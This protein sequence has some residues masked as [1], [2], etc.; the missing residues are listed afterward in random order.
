MIDFADNLLQISSIDAKRS[1]SLCSCLADDFENDL[2]EYKYFSDAHL[3]Y[4]LTLVSVEKYY[5]KPGIWNFILA[6]NNSRDALR[7]VQFARIT[8]TFVDHFGDYRDKELCFT[9]CDFIARN[10]EPSK[11]ISLLGQLKKYELR[12]SEDLRGYAAEGLYIVEQEIKRA[13]A[14]EPGRAG[15]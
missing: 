8:D 2:M 5:Q 11:A 6:I 14:K 13:N 15:S 12:K 4:F 3:D 9:V 1:A 7:E 10:I